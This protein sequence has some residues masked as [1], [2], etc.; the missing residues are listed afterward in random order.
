MARAASI[1]VIGILFNIACEQRLATALGE[2]IVRRVSAL[3]MALF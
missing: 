2:G 3:V 1:F